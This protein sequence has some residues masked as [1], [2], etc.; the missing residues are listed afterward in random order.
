MQSPGAISCRIFEVRPYILS[1]RLAFFTPRKPGPSF[2]PSAAYST[3]P[4]YLTITFPAS[5]LSPDWPPPAYTCPTLRSS[6]GRPG[7][8]P[9]A[10]PTASS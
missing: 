8:P 1:F 7:Q 5:A 10:A 4:A 3:M 9:S 6:A 2:R